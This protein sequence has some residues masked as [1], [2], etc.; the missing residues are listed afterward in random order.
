MSQALQWLIE[1][2]F[3]HHEGVQHSQVNIRTQWLNDWVVYDIIMNK[4][5]AL[6]RE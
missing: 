6:V 3:L 2:H 1:R 5:D 4:F